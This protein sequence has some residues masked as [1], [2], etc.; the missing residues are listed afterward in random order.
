MI[1]NKELAEYLYKEITEHQSDTDVRRT[2]PQVWRTGLFFNTS[3]LEYWIEQFK[4]RGCVGH[5]EWS[6]EYQK[7]IWIKDND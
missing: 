1:D 6:E 3:D 2:R 7:N 4:C 5:S